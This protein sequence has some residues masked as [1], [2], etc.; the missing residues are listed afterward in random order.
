V[1]LALRETSDAASEV[2]SSQFARDGCALLEGFFTPDRIDRAGSAVRRL[3]D[4]KPNR[5]VVDSLRTGRRSFWAQAEDP[6][7]EQFRFNDL[8]LMSE[9]VRALALDADLAETLA[10]LLGETVALSNSRNFAK[11]SSQPL[12]IDSLTMTPRTPHALI[13]VWIAFEDIHPDSGPLV[14]FPGSHRIPLYTFN[15]GTHHESRDEAYDWFDYIDVQIRLRGL[16]ERALL[17]RKGDVFIWHADL[18]HGGRQVADMNRTRSSLVCHYFRESDCIER[19]ADLVPLNGAHWT[20]R[21]PEAVMLDPS[22]YGARCPFPEDSYLS[23]H[24]DVREA[25]ECGHCPS[26]E[27]HF[28][29]SGH[30][31]GRGV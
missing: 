15:D 7:T 24:E 13:A 6:E 9:E 20:R 14:Y 23:R 11:G 12:H 27:H 22:H 8:Y 3:L 19:G 10:V 17:A 4:E 29:T 18:A 31:E 26:G 25:V 21:Q 1:N 30:A 5:V 16:R 2:G 28:R